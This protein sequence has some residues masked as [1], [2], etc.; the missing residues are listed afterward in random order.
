MAQKKTA[1]WVFVVAQF[2]AFGF[3]SADCPV[4][5]K[6]NAVPDG[7]SASAEEMN[8]AKSALEAFEKAVKQFQVCVEA[9]TKTK[10]AALGKNVDAIKQLRMMSDRRLTVF[11]DE[12]QKQADSYTE[13]MSAWKLTN[14]Q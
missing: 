6:P 12:L 2:A 14:R 10:A 8:T 1:L 11:N 7:S 5:K 4:P 13:Q 3:A 9:D